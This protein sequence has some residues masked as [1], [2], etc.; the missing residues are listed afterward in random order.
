MIVLYEMQPDGM[1]GST[2][3]EIRRWRANTE[4]SLLRIA[5]QIEHDYD[6]QISVRGATY[7][8]YVLCPNNG[9]VWRL[10]LE[11][12]RPPLPSEPEEPMPKQYLGDSVY[13]VFDGYHV[14]L[15]TENGYP[16]DPRNVIHLEPAVYEALVRYVESLKARAALAAAKGD[17]HDI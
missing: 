10:I 15:T 9:A 4:Q 11:L 6:C 12:V 7:I 16:D 17:R 13:V 1:G 14:T 5:R 2:Q 3:R 8:G